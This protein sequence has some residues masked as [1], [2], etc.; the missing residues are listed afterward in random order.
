[1]APRGQYYR[2]P[3][4]FV[5]ASAIG[6][7]GPDRGDEELTETSDRGDG[8]LAELV[9]SWERATEPAAASGLRVVNVR[10]GLVQSPRGG[11]LR[12]QY[13]QFAAGL[14]GRIGDGRMWQ[15]WISIDDLV[16]IYHQALYDR[17]MS[18][19]VNAVSPHP[20]RNADY[21]ATLAAVLHRPALL[22]VP[23]LGPRILLG[24]EGADEL[25]NATQR[26]IPA[27]LLRTGH[28][29]RHPS[30]DSALRHLLGQPPPDSP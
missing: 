28:D 13:P 2:G 5:C 8:F 10:T 15:S 18:G 25:A 26:V 11:V 1:M 30:L 7:Y 24:R 21:T 12:L 14:G 6:F 29:F 19:P 27:V 20:V 9:E 22:P 17:G 16:D 4:V 3:T 23:R